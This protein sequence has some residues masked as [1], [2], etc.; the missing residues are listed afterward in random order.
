MLIE[1]PDFSYLDRELKDDELL[2]DQ[3][4]PATDAEF[5]EAYREAVDEVF[6]E[7]EKAYYDPKLEA[8]TEEFV[9]RLKSCKTEE[10]KKKVLKE[11]F[12]NRFD[13]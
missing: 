13:F 9:K 8:E 3:Y 11:E 2:N 1:V 5:G 10:E 6:A 4:E 12:G 7:W